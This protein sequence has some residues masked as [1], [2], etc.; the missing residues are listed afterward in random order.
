MY[1]TLLD[2]EDSDDEDSDDEDS[3]NDA[4]VLPDTGAADRLQLIG[5]TGIALTILGMFAVIAT[6]RPPPRRHRA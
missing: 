5:E 2:D 3:D 4:A 6:P 1:I